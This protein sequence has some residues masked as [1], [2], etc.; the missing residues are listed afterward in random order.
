MEK[1]TKYW[2]C[3]NPNCQ[4]HIGKMYT[5]REEAV[6][7]ANRLARHHMGNTILVFEV[8]DAYLAIPPTAEQ[9]IVESA[10]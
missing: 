7:E 8:V 3:H 2:M 10:K 9:V 5:T 6:K 1:V 4:A